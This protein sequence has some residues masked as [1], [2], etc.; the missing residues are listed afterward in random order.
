MISDLR[1]KVSGTVQ[2]LLRRAPAVPPVE[3][4]GADEGAAEAGIVSQFLGGLRVA[5]ERRRGWLRSSTSRPIRS[6]PRSR[7]IQLPKS[8]P[9]RTSNFVSRPIRRICGG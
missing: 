5:P 8:T 7:R 1:R 4:P 6:L 3:A 9:H 2:S